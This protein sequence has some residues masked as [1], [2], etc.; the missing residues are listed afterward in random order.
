MISSRDKM[1]FDKIATTSPKILSTSE[2]AAQLK[3]N[4]TSGDILGSLNL[5]GCIGSSC[6]DTGTV[7]DISGQ[8]C[9]P[10]VLPK[11]IEKFTMNSSSSVVPYEKSEFDKYDKV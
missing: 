10:T 9:K 6:C 1:D 5:G 4:Q 3:E 7:W 8:M 2:I 11:Q